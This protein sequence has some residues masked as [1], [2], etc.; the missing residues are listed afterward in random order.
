MTRIRGV[1]GGGALGNK[2]SHVNAP[3][4][5]PRVDHI[6]ANRP[7]QIG[8]QHFLPKEPLYYNR[9][10]A[11]TPTGPNHNFEVGP[12][13]GREILKSGSQAPCRPARPMSGGGRKF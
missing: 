9:V 3:K 7:S 13:A 8:L 2:V 6:S 12:G 10:S 1:T 11:S 4:I 5:E